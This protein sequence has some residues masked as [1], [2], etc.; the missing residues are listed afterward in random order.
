[1]RIL[2]WEIWHTYAS[3]LH[4]PVPDLG[5]VAATIVERGWAKVAVASN[6][7]CYWKQGEAVQTGQLEIRNLNTF[8][9]AEVV[10]PP[11]VSGE[12]E[13]FLYR[14]A[15][16]K[17]GESTHFAG[18]ALPPP[19]IRAS[20]GTCRFIPADKSHPEMN[21]EVM[22]KL[23]ATGDLLIQLRLKGWDDPI[24]E[25]LFAT[26]TT[27]PSFQ[28][29]TQVVVPLGL[30]GYGPKFVFLGEHG[31][32][33]RERWRAFRQVRERSAYVAQAREDARQQ[34]RAVDSLATSFMKAP[35]TPFPL[36]E[37]FVRLAEGLAFT[38]SNAREGWTYVPLGQKS[39][40]RV[41]ARVYVRSH[42]HIVRH[43]DQRQTAT[44]NEEAHGD[45]FT[46]LLLGAPRGT[47]RNP[48]EH[49]GPNL[50]MWEDFGLYV[51]PSAVL[52]V[53]SA[54]GRDAREKKAQRARVE[55]FGQY[56][57]PNQPLAELMDYSHVLH[58]RWLL[59][60]ELPRANPEDAFRAQ[61]DIIKLEDL[62][63]AISGN[64]EVQNILTA[65]DRAVGTD[66]IRDRL[67]QYLAVSEAEVSFREDR[68]WNRAA[69][70]LSV[71]FGVLSI[72]TLATEVIKPLW[73]YYMGSPISADPG[74]APLLYL[75]MATV[76][77][78]L[79][80]LAGFAWVRR[81]R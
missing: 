27:G 16:I 34:G 77:V 63:S 39:V 37:F 1:M 66:G 54:G 25:D 45:F 29:F 2:D 35:G 68:S 74:L 32:G 76:F 57:Y 12:V 38:M 78:G 44:E 33:I 11:G 40:V 47:P 75:L 30:A 3:F 14:A 42:L 81:V 64:R 41:G 43:E 18:A 79:G 50:R 73:C 31:L 15:F 13:A 5:Q 60:A 28:R 61:R 46:R 67:R 10:L 69:T 65:S 55:R 52:Y 80:L 36:Y 56:S 20:V 58:R 71:L 9:D 22:L 53:W 62:V 70:V 8:G 24:S 6:G 72:P 23:H 51:G 59:Q 7:R 48:R 4:S 49:L 17:A 21:G 26:I 19:Y